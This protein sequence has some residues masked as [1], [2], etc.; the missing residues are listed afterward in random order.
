[1]ISIK[2]PNRISIY[3]IEIIHSR[4]NLNSNNFCDRHMYGRYFH[5]YH[6]A[7]NRILYTCT[8]IEKKIRARLCMSVWR[9]ENEG[10]KMLSNSREMTL[11]ILFSSIELHLYLLFFSKNLKIHSYLSETF[12]N[13]STNKSSIKQNSDSWMEMPK[14]LPKI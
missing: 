7:H 3:S 13:D 12:R 9:R 1:M 10:R 11:L 6:I 8:L 2:F 5:S 14:E 4:E